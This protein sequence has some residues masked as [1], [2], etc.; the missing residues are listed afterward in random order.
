L[1]LPHLKVPRSALNT[2][3]D[4]ARRFV[5]QSWSF[6]RIKAVAKAFDGTFNDAVLAMCAGAL[7]EYLLNHAELPEE[8]L[9]TL[10]P[11]SLRQAGDVD[12]SNAVAAIS[13]DL[14][15]NIVD[16]AERFKAIQTSVRA[17]KDYYADMSPAEIELL[18]MILQAPAMLLMPLGLVSKLP[19]YNVAISNVPG[20][21]QPMYWNGARMDGSYPLSI[22]T[23]GMALNITLVTYGD[24]VD[25]GIIACRRSVPQ[26]QRLI[27]YMENSL[28]ELEDAAGLKTKPAR[29]RGTKKAK[30]AR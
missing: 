23:D 12:S 9:K 2:P 6:Q 20:I 4:G 21:R 22:V 1:S 5:A 7:R 8:S 14:A 18:F 25:F 13:A 10:V 17:G 16:P 11:V 19:P 28:A 29:K 3:V 24:N 30:A 15:T 27:D 26:V